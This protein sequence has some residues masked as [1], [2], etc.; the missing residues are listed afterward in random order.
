MKK[1]DD[2]N[3]TQNMS[4]KNLAWPGRAEVQVCLGQPQFTQGVPTYLRLCPLW[5]SMCPSLEDRI[6]GHLVFGRLSATRMRK[7]RE[8]G[9]G[10]AGL[11]R[12]RDWL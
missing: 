12:Q 7:S 4:Q 3:I 11:V 5:S 8:R 6:C 10:S 9:A 1:T 2:G